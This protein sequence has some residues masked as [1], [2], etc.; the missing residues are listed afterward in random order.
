MNDVAGLAPADRHLERVQHQLGAQVIG[1]RPTND[2]P[3]PGIQNDSQIEETA[4]RRHEGDVGDPE[5]VRLRCHEVAVHQVR[6]RP[7]VLV[8]AC[9]R[10]T[11]PAAARTYQAGRAHSGRSACG[12]AFPRRAHSSACTRGIPWSARAGVDGPHPLQ[13]HL[14]CNSM[15]RR[16]ALPP[17]IIA[18]LRHGEHACHCRD[19][20]IGRFALM[21]SKTRTAL[22]RFP[23][24]NEAAARERMSRSN[25]NCLF[26][27]RKRANSSRS[28]GLR[29]SPFSSRRPSCRSD[30]ATQVRIDCPV[31]SNSRARSSGSRP[32]RTNSTIWRRNSANTADGSGH[33]Q[34]LW[35]QK[36]GR[37]T[38]PG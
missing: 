21:N 7:R 11:R 10:H 8:A 14:V 16:R 12:R 18:R 17:R 6:R 23:A 30:C 4:R 13:K 24:R 1:H 38:E 3:A 27:R 9:R 22:L 35:K 37:P 15:G 28:A 32:A 33:R 5:L 34:S 2:F 36:L 20:E 29:A 26:S 19:R 25:R 31:G